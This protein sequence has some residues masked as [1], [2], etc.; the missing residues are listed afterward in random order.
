MD[1]APPFLE[2]VVSI[3]NWSLGPP[4]VG[5]KTPNSENWLVNPVWCWFALQKYFSEIPGHL[6]IDEKWDE[7]CRMT[8][9]KSDE[10]VANYAKK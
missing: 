9:L 7:W 8:T 6:L 1:V 10:E 4:I 2:G 5:R 3:S